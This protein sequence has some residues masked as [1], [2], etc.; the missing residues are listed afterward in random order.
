[1]L[2]SMGVGP[3]MSIRNGGRVWK[4]SFQ[5][6]ALTDFGFWK[7]LLFLLP[8]PF[9]FLCFLEEIRKSFLVDIKKIVWV[10]FYVSVSYRICS[11]VSLQLFSQQ[12]RFKK[13]SSFFLFS[14][15]SSLRNSTVRLIRR[16]GKQRSAIRS[17]SM[18]SKWRFVR[19]CVHS[20]AATQQHKIRDR[21]WST[22]F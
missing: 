2:Y 7:C 15:S 18:R 6:M 9:L 11:T 12:T 13:S 22:S 10:Q 3:D 1:M 21:K 5:G 17:I 16:L 4:A 20:R 19:I 8:V 14:M